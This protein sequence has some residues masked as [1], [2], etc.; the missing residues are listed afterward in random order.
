M[1]Q[2]YDAPSGTAPKVF[3]L[4]VNCTRD[5]IRNADR[6]GGQIMQGA[7]RR[8]FWAWHPAIIGGNSNYVRV[9]TERDA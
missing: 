3:M 4:R 7:H 5:V 6:D 9:Y 1:L 2:A 8:R